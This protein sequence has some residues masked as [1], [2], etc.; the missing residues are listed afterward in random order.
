MREKSTLGDHL[1]D[2]WDFGF[3]CSVEEENEGFSLLSFLWEEKSRF[4]SPTLRTL[5]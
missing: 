1:H 4:K 3:S 5:S 2:T